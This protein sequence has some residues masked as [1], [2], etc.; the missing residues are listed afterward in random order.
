MIRLTRSK[1]RSIILRQ[2]VNFLSLGNEDN[3]SKN[4]ENKDLD[5]EE[6]FFLNLRNK[7]TQNEKILK[8]MSRIV[9]ENKIENMNSILDN[10]NSTSKTDSTKMQK[11]IGKGNCINKR[12]SS[13]SQD[14]NP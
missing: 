13:Q 1:H 3:T 5:G 9:K 4:D 12:R 11:N 2:K 6:V 8:D 10:M 14:Q 7:I